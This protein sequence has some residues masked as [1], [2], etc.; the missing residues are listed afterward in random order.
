MISFSSTFL[1]LNKAA[2]YKIYLYLLFINFFHKKIDL[3]SS[4]L[5]FVYKNIFIKLIDPT[6][7]LSF[8]NP[9]AHKPNYL[10]F[11]IKLPDEKWPLSQYFFS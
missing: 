1:F 10:D 9:R 6:L 5:F 11:V 7:I 3:L 4:R 8:E 2:K